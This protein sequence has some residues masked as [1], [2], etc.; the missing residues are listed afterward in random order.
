MSVNPPFF[1]QVQQKSLKVINSTTPNFGFR[2]SGLVTGSDAWNFTNPL[3]IQAVTN[4]STEPAIA[5][6]FISH[7]QPYENV[8]AGLFYSSAQYQVYLNGTIIKPWEL[9]VYDYRNTRGNATGVNENKMSPP[10]AI[11]AEFSN[12]DA[13]LEIQPGD[14]LQVEVRF[15][16]AHTAELTEPTF[17]NFYNG[18]LSLELM[19]LE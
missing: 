17:V 5:K 13:T 19:T 4:S 14:T 2:G 11:Y 12:G 15:R 18:Q 9:F 10:T 7:P 3:L 8:G 6:A 16:S 1:Q